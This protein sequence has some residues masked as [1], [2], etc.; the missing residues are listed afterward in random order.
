MD[1]NNKKRGWFAGSHRDDGGGADVKAP[2]CN[3]SGEF[4]NGDGGKSQDCSLWQ[5]LCNEE[6]RRAYI[7]SITI[8]NPFLRDFVA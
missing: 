7:A 3:D 8:M 5:P 2:S 4:D 1:K 6:L